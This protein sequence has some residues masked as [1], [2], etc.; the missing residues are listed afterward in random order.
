MSHYDIFK[1][2]RGNRD[3]VFQSLLDRLEGKPA[4]ILE[5]GVARD[6]SPGARQGDGWS[7]MHF[8][9]YVS[10][11]GGHLDLVDVSQDSLTNCAALM[12]SIPREFSYETHLA[13]GR[14]FLKEAGQYDIILIDGSDD[15]VEMVECFELATPKTKLILCDDFHAKGHLLRRLRPQFRLFVWD[16]NAHEMALY[17][18][19]DLKPTTVKMPT[20]Q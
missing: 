8:G 13:D 4:R 3:T 20:I 6:L 7:S 15:P 16:N 17:D 14:A 9:E 19:D 12:K 18:A 2:I 1:T 10:L 5:I 11:H